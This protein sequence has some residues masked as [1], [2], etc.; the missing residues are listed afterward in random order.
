MVGPLAPESLEEAL[1]LLAGKPRPLPFAGGTEIMV[2][3]RAG[4]YLFLH[5][6]PELRGIGAAGEGIRIGAGTS[7]AELIESPLSPPLL[8]RAAEGV[9]A[10]GIRNLGTI[11][12][13]ICNAS[14]A[15]D[16]LPPLYLY[17]AVLVLASLGEGKIVYR[18]LPIE[19]FILGVKKTALGEDELLVSL[20]IPAAL[21]SHRTYEK[22]GARRA[23]AVSKVSFAAAALVEGGKLRDF[24]AA[25]GAAGPRVLRCRDIERSLRGAAVPGEELRG[26][27]V[28]AYGE[29][30]RPIDDQ[31]STAEYRLTVC[32]KLL[33]DFL[34]TLV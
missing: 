27:I 25:F 1:K 19:D 3:R 12:G 7:F 11:G 34:S 30:L 10:P 15:G 5:R 26:S 28:R 29:R 13:N 2:R 24:R 22:A 31:R 33:G 4:D 6:I 32:L 16:S 23:Q 21:F 17:D 18:R 8:R 14:P 20:E 9:G